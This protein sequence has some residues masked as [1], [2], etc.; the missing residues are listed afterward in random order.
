MWG[1][2]TFEDNVDRFP[3]LFRNVMRIGARQMNDLSRRIC[4][5]STEKATPRLARGLVRLCDQIGRPV[6]GH[7]EIDLTQEALAQMTAM[8][9]YSVNRQLS[10]WERQDLVIRH[11]SIIVI[12]DLQSLKR[13][14]GAVA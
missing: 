9:P 1:L 7:F 4:E 13:L 3:G 11:R 6:N 10:E 8:N 12:R 2:W 14:C 5:V